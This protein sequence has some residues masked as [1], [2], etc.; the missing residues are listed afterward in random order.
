MNKIIV[1]GY[2]GSG[3]SAATDLLSEYE[4]VHCPNGSY[5]YIF[6]HCPNGVFDLEDKLL[7]GNTA[8]R[9]DEALRSFRRAMEDLFGN[10]RWW[11]ADYEHRLSPRFMEL[12]DSYIDRLA[13]CRFP[14]FWYEQEKTSRLSYLAERVRRRCGTS[15]WKMYASDLSMAFPSEEEFFSA[16]REFFSSIFRELAVGQEQKALL[17][18]QLFLPHNLFRLKRYFPENDVKLVVVSRDPRDVFTLNKYFWLP[19]GSPVPIPTNVRDCC[20]YYRAMRQAERPCDDSRILRLSFEELVLDYDAAKS[21]LEH[22]LEGWLGRQARPMEKLNPRISRENIG[23]FA[24][25]DEYGKEAAFIKKELVEYLYSG[26][27][28]HLASA[29]FGRREGVF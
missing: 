3:S 17:L 19:Q 24:R 27:E 23:V 9:S 22:F 2:M 20:R 13:T 28:E 25:E 1:A 8:L 10:G 6:A 12:V 14:G 16:T 18:D 4:Q 7:W 29:S 11:F 5:E 26:M 15:R 21:R